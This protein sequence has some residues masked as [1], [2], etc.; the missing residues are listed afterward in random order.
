MLQGYKLI[1]GGEL[2]MEGSKGMSGLDYLAFILVI[3]GAVNWGLVGLFGLDL[4]ST[5]FG[6]MTML[7]RIV[8]DLVGLSG[9]YCI[10]MLT[11]MSR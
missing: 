11:K 6:N 10:F 8:Y 3:I 4:V 2:L 1:K 5:L 9:V 7:S